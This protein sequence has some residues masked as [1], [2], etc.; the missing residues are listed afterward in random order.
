MYYSASLASNARF[1]CVGAATASSVTGPYIPLSEP[2]FCDTSIGGAIDSNS[3]EDVIGEKMYVVYK[4]D[5][6]AIGRGGAC[7][8]TVAPIVPT[9]IILQEVS[10]IDGVT[11]IGEG[12]QLLTN[13]AED[14]PKVEAPT[15]FYD[16]SQWVLFYNSGCFVDTS[17]RIRYATSDSII[18][19]YTRRGTFLETGSTAAN[20]QV[21]GGIDVTSDGTKAVF[22]GDLNLAW[23]N[24]G[25]DGSPRVRGMYAIELDSSGGNISP[26]AFL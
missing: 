14:G 2:L 15:M 23:L 4:V 16:G 7:G 11:L 9:P 10:A 18:G 8:N 22:H 24:G 1:H 13:T 3:V 26:G 17:Y 25:S 5:G 19:P 21:P 6:N 20:V 12:I